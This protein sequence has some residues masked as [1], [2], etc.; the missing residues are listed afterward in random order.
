[1]NAT[2]VN[3]TQV[4][5]PLLADLLK[6]SSIASLEDFSARLNGVLKVLIKLLLWR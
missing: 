6:A 1:M 5:G 3:D 2:S 4:I